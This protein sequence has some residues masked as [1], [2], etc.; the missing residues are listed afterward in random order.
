MNMKSLLSFPLM[1]LL[2][3]AGFVMVMTHSVDLSYLNRSQ[4]WDAALRLFLT[5]SIIGG[6]VALLSIP[7]RFPSFRNRLEAMGV[8]IV[9]FALLPPISAYAGWL[10]WRFWDLI[11]GNTFPT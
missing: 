9:W 4:L 7:F 6:V 10:L 1:A 3:L 5:G 8:A 11:T 2:T